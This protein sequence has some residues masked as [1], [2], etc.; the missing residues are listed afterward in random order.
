MKRVIRLTEGDLHRIIKNSVNRILK[1]TEDFNYD[2]YYDSLKDYLN[3]PVDMNN[4]EPS[5]DEINAL[6]GQFDF[7]DTD[8]SDLM[9][10]NQF[11]S[12]RRK[13]KRLTEAFNDFD[14]VPSA[15]DYEGIESNGLDN[16]DRFYNYDNT[17]EYFPEIDEFNLDAS[18]YRR[19]DI[20]PDDLSESRKRLGRIIRESINKVLKEGGM[21]KNGMLTRDG[22]ISVNNTNV[23][24][25]QKEF[26]KK[27]TPD[28]KKR[29][30]KK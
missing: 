20:D 23:E 4:Y 8:F 24:N 25:R 7:D 13:G 15:N 18:N 14:Y 30:V 21:Y 16:Y 28:F 3:N 10:N 9:S 29:K 27:Y 1:E 22:A 17:D 26:N 19:E 2:G 11:E 5:D 6:D 12:K